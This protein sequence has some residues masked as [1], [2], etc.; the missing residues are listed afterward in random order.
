MDENIEGIC[1][2]EMDKIEGDVKLIQRK[3]VTLGEVAYLG[4]SAREG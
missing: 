2:A 3:I 1:L 4:L